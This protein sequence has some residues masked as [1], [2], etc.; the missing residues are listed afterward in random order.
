M[1]E[2]GDD[3]ILAKSDS[4]HDEQCVSLLAIFAIDAGIAIGD[5]ADMKLVIEKTAVK[6]LTKI[7]PDLRAAI[8]ARLA[9][10]ATDPFGVHANVKALSGEKD[11]FRLRHGDW[12]VVYRV[13]RIA[14]EVRVLVV[15]TRGSTYR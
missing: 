6:R 9:E 3:A 10:I 8:L 4:R 5:N 2:E 7:Q 1:K 13:V 15:D 14:G 12:R 11:L